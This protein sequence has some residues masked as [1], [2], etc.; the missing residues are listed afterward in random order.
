MLVLLGM[1]GTTLVLLVIS[2]FDLLGFQILIFV[3]VFNLLG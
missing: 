1:K 3:F 2:Q